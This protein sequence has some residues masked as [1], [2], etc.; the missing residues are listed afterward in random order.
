MLSIHITRL[1][2]TEIRLISKDCVLEEIN[3]LICSRYDKLKGFRL[4]SLVDNYQ[5]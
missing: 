3:V 4:L 1:F 5:H 2:Y